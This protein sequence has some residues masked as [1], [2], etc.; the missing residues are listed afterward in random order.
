MWIFFEI[1]QGIIKRNFV[2]AFIGIPKSR[3]KIRIRPR[4]YLHQKEGPHRT[5]QGINQGM[6][7]RLY[8]G[9]V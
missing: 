4:K 2:T 5:V 1:G 9:H 8:D 7:G 3:M 6:N